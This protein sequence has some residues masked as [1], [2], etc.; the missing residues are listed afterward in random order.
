MVHPH[1]LPNHGELKNTDVSLERAIG[2]LLKRD[3]DLE[4][5]EFGQ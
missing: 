5:G 3:R 2:N 1:H 4:V